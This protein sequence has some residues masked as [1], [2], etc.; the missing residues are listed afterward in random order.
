MPSFIL[1]DPEHWRNRAEE[2]RSVAEQMW[3]P[4]RS[5]RCFASLQT[6]KSW[7]HTMSCGRERN[8]NHR[9]AEELGAARANGPYGR[10]SSTE[11]TIA[12]AAAARSARCFCVRSCGC[13]GQLVVR[14][15]LCC[16]LRSGDNRGATTFTMKSLGARPPRRRAELTG[17]G[18]AAIPG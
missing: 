5:A 8:R 3:T 15:Y 16:R 18:L 1:D 11:A 12:G 13:P 17:D 9:R 4:K 6:M 7:P 14:R 10:S 2:V